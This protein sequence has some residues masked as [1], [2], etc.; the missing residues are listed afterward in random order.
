MSRSPSTFRQRDVTVA[1]KAAHAAGVEVTGVVVDPTS[2]QIKIITS[3]GE[4]DEA[5]PWL[6]DMEKP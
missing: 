4:T 2:G 1:I 6:V 3:K 5:N